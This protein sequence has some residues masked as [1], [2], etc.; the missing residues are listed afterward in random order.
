MDRSYNPDSYDDP[1]EHDRE[2]SLGTPTILGIFFGLALI[3]A[4]FFGL[5]YSMGRHSA[6]PVVSTAEPATETPTTSS[7]T[8]PPSGLPGETPAHDQADVP[9]TAPEPKA[10]VIPAVASI[11]PPRPS[12]PVEKP[13]PTPAAA[14]AST[15]TIIVQIAAVSHREDADVL[16]TTLQRRGYNVVIRQEPQDKLLHVQVGPFPTRKDADAMRQ[17]LLADG[18][19]AIVK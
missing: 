2:I 7:A 12:A 19:N 18:Y 13:A 17:R 15:G 1:I 11:P 3:C 16:L 4:L 10:K 9:E 14:P 8:K 6:Q 5:G